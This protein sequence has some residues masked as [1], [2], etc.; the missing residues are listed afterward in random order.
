MRIASLIASGLLCSM[1][2]FCAR[3][4]AADAPRPRVTLSAGTLEGTLPQSAPGA[5]FKGIPFAQPPLGPLRWHEPVAVKSW[6]GVKDAA[7]P[8]AACVQNGRDGPTGSEDCLYLN[9]WTPQWPARSAYPVMLWL[10]GGANA[11]GSA[12]NPVFDGAALARHGVVV[13]TANFRVGVMGFMAHPA[14]STE[15]PQNSSGNYTLLDQIMALRWIRDNIARFGGDPRHVTVFGQSSGSYDLLLLMTSPLAKGLFVNAIAQSGQFLSYGGSMPKA[16]AEAIG[17]KIAAEL[18]APEGSGTLAYLRGLP[19]EQVVTA[20]TKLL[21]TEPGT[22]T[23]LL[24]NV[25]G[26]VLPELAARVFAQ[27]RQMPIPLL[28]G[29]NAREI[30][31]QVPV[32]ELRQRITA[33]YGDLAPKALEVYGLANGN[34]GHD[35]P[36]LGGPGSQWWTDTVQRCAAIMETSWHA[37]AKNP[38]WQYQFER[39]IPGRETAGSTHGAEVA[40]VFGTLDRV[41]PDKPAFT[42]ADRKASEQMRE[43]WTNFAKTGDPNGGSL[44]AWPRAGNGRYL[45]FTA[46]GP[47]I[48]EN[49]QPGPC[50]VFREWTLQRLTN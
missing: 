46:E 10:F 32:E 30:P 9:V 7:S 42:D 49:L 14:L 48:K 38:T 25:D 1:P 43:Y 22:D 17:T 39:S 8:G 36:L 23:G 41:G 44:P 33:M 6:Q 19:A 26:W 40:F 20:A 29:N 11:V 50:N 24:T 47:M 37:A 27:G 12:N 21:P 45:A 16:R 18:K 3:S 4:T 34:Q 15:S 2:L 5:V 13:V 31:W 35:D 28:I